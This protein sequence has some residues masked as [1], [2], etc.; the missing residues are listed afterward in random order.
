M[1]RTG[2]P[3]V[4]SDKPMSDIRTDGSHAQWREHYQA[5]VLEIDP[6]KSLKLI[7]AAH[8]ATLDQIED[9]FSK[10][11]NAEQIAL[12]NALEMLRRLRTIAET[13]SANRKRLP[14]RMLIIVSVSRLA[15]N[16]VEI[17]VARP[18]HKSSS[19]RSTRRK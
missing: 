17:R 6:R 10:P 16:T 19:G 9:G 1:K 5:V 7:A 14:N 15:D 18:P 4:R 2:G 11:A 12:R 8:S 13:R 3:R